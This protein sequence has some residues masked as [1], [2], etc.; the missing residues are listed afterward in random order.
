M[1]I[2]NPCKK[3]LVRACCKETCDDKH[4]YLRGAGI[5]KEGV[6]G[7]TVG[8]TIGLSILFLIKLFFLWGLHK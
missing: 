4:R 6:I 1:L 5:F 8:S 7:F 2:R 3:C